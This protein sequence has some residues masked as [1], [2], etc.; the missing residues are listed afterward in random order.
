MDDATRTENEI[1]PSKLKPGDQ[2]R[3][4]A[5]PEIFTVIGSDGSLVTL[6]SAHGVECRSGWR[7]IRLVEGER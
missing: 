5:R 6:R 2:V 1:P 3:I 7:V 4:G